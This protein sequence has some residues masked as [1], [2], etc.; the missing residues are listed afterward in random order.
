MNKDPTLSLE[1][2]KDL[3]I[4]DNNLNDAMSIE[5]MVA[6]LDD[7]YTQ[8]IPPEQAKRVSAR[9]AGSVSS[10]CRIAKEKK[11]TISGDLILRS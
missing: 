9:V 5:A 11:M 2:Q 10:T 7:P 3:H 8:Y 4:S 1:A 6:Q